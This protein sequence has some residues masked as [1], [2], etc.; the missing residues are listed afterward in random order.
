MNDYVLEETVQGA[1]VLFVHFSSRNKKPGKFDRFPTP[2]YVNNIYVNCKD[3]NWYLNGI[4]G[5]GDIKASIEYLRN[6]AIE[7]EAKK[8][9]CIGS[10]MG[11]W[12]AA[13]FASALNAELICFGTELFLNLHSGYSKE[14]LTVAP[15]FDLQRFGIPKKAL[16]IAGICS[17]CDVLCINSLSN[18][19]QNSEV[20]YLR[21]CGHESARRLKD[22][23]LLE[24]TIEKFINNEIDMIPEKE[25]I[26]PSI[27][28]SISPSISNINKDSLELFCFKLSEHL[29]LAEKIALC[30]HL[31]A[32]RTY[33]EPA[34]LIENIIEE[35]GSI[36]SL[37]LTYA[38]C[39]RKLKRFDKSISVLK[40][41]EHIPLLRQQALFIKAQIIEKIGNK[42]D[43]LEIYKIIHK[44]HSKNAVYKAV[45]VKV[46]S[47]TISQ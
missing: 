12:G 43:A 13:L 8:I 19:W 9:I 29:S 1:E 6:R 27:V 38:F 37:L 18:T 46:E 44:E 30:E 47:L 24:L 31:V 15:G 17:P 5:L 3:N 39:L 26:Q 20:L 41:I 14:N 42:S 11:A 7:L 33:H 34:N 25:T 45:S 4:P 35:Y 10:S 23:G 2:A 40:K 21:H 22:M 16:M 28:S 32:R 36:P